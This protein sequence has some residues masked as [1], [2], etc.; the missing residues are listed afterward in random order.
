DEEDAGKK[1]D[2]IDHEM[3][4]GIRNRRPPHGHAARSRDTS[5]RSPTDRTGSR[6]RRVR[7]PGVFIA[8][9]LATGETGTVSGLP[10]SHRCSSGSSFCRILPGFRIVFMI[11]V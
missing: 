4:E 6:S 7:G 9:F 10:G 11:R 3:P 5:T 2:E 8:I 1:D